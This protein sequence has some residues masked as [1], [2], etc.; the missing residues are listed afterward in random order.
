MDKT[1][2]AGKLKAEGYAEIETK[3]LEANCTNTEHAHEFDVRAMVLDG[4][5]T[6]T[7]GGESRTY[8]SGD[9]FNMAAGCA[10]AE[11]VGAQGVRYVVGR[12]RR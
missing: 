10:H 7:S 9:V 6:L 8:R 1:E 4:E 2:F 3:G 12:R 11:R 5:I